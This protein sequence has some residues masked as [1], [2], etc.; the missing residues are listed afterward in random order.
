MAVLQC[1]AEQLA[2]LGAELEAPLYLAADNS[3][4]SCLASGSTGAIEALCAACAERG[5]EASY[6]PGYRAYHS[7]IVSAAQAPYRAALER[8]SYRAPQCEVLSTVDLASYDG[9]RARTIDRLVEQYVTPARF[10]GAIRTLYQRG[11]RIF[12]E[13]GPKRPLSAYVEDTLREYD[14]ACHASIHPKTGEIESL[15]RMF[16]FAFV[17][18]VGSL[19]EVPER[20]VTET[21]KMTAQATQQAQASERFA[22]I[23]KFV[24][25][26][27][28]ERTGYPEDM[29]EL[30]LDL[31]GDLGI[32][33]VKQAETFSRARKHFGLTPARN[34]RMRDYNTLRKVIQFFVEQTALSAPEIAAE[35]KPAVAMPRPTPSKPIAVP[36]IPKTETPKPE[37]ARRDKSSG[38]RESVI[39]P[40]ERPAPLQTSVPSFEVKERRHDFIQAH[41]AFEASRAGAPLSS[42]AVWDVLLA[43]AERLVDQP[44]AGAIDL[45]QYTPVALEGDERKALVITAELSGPDRVVARA[46]DANVASG[47]IVSHE[48]TFVTAGRKATGLTRRVEERLARAGYLGGLMPLAHRSRGLIRVGD[49]V[50]GHVWAHEISFV[51]AVGGLLPSAIDHQ[52]RPSLLDGAIS[53]LALAFG[54]RL[55]RGSLAESAGEIWFGARPDEG[56]ALSCYVVLRE[57]E[58]DA[59]AADI[60]V[61]RESG[62]PVLEI[63]RARLANASRAGWL[64][65]RSD[66]DDTSLP[67]ESYVG[68]TAS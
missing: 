28:A 6:L 55:G 37:A 52:A 1:G 68:R 47:D 58:S 30:D 12:L 23:Q 53:V 24:V 14:R 44:I 39:V 10:H 31:E 62:E 29:L 32:D 50:D 59:L 40:R 25:T 9:D 41:V 54:Q 27:L 36:S 18:G 7:P 3:P 34:V 21:A 35:P 42:V 43:A 38:V 22:A 60:R 13:C 46:I 19:T 63:Q 61:V 64:A 17:A 48:A 65:S 11:A 66:E 16:G 20:V 57:I 51:E 45:V 49:M 8:L 56:E 4:N 33:T 5:I 15:Q 67:T 2:E 26:A